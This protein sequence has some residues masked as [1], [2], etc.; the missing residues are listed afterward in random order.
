MIGDRNKIFFNIVHYILS[1]Q[2]NVDWILKSSFINFTGLSTE[3][4]SSKFQKP[5]LINEILEYLTEI[6]PYH[7]KFDQF[8][9][10][11]TSKKDTAN[12]QGDR[13]TTSTG[14]ILIIPNLVEFFNL[15]YSIRFD[16]VTLNPDEEKY[17]SIKSSDEMYD[18]Y[19]T[20]SANRLYAL[21]TKDRDLIKELLKGGFKGLTVDGGNFLMDRVGYDSVPYDSNLYD[22]P[23]ITNM[24]FI[25]DYN[26]PNLSNY[27]KE[28]ISIG[29]NL[30]KTNH[31][32]PLNRNNLKIISEY[33]DKTYEITDYNI[34][35]DTI[36]IFD[37]IRQYE[38]ITITVTDEN[39][40][41]TYY[42]FTGVDFFEDNSDTGVK[43]FI[44]YGTISFPIPVNTYNMKAMEVY[45]ENKN[46]SRTLLTNYSMDGNNIIL[47]YILD[48]FNK[49]IISIIDYE[50][51]YDKIYTYED[52]YA[53]ANNL[54]YLD[55]AGFLRPHW[56]DNHPSE[57]N[58]SRILNNMFIKTLNDDNTFNKVSFYNYLNKNISVD[59]EYAER[60]ELARELKIGDK[61][62]YVNNAKILQQPSKTDNDVII[63][64]VIL[65]DNELIEFHYMNNNILSGIKRACYGSSFKLSYPANT[66]VYDVNGNNSYNVSELPYDYIAYNNIDTLSYK[67]KGEINDYSVINVFKTYRINMLNNLSPTSTYI[68]FDAP[69]QEN[70]NPISI[71]Y[72]I[73]DFFKIAKTDILGIKIG[74][75]VIQIEF[76]KDIK[77]I[78]SLITYLNNN[79]PAIYNL[80]I[81][82]NDDIISFTSKNGENIT[83]YN[84]SGYPIQALFNG[85]LIGT[86]ERPEIIMDGKSGLA[87][88]NRKIIWGTHKYKIDDLIKNPIQGDVND[89]IQS[90]NKNQI[91]SQSILARNNS[92]KL[93]IISLIGENITLSNIGEQNSLEICG[94][95]E[96]L[97]LDD[98][99][100]YN[101]SL[102]SIII[103]KEK[104]DI[105]SSIDINGYKIY[106]QTY[107]EY[108][109]NG[110]RM[111]SIQNITTDKTINKDDAI[112]LSS[113]PKEL[114]ENVDYTIDGQYI[115]LKEPLKEYEVIYITNNK[116]A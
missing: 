7:T 2:F 88:N 81:T 22:A 107:N 46:G 64:G 10:K 93:E 87:I 100:S 25:V 99:I 59:L 45:I 24:Y 11:Y 4:S 58:I 75:N 31:P 104:I 71:S 105:P 20:T 29:V 30:L 3:I 57:L 72:K 39:Y 47:P 78:K 43:E 68:N 82:Y 5:S 103:S 23:T 14:E 37:G 19:N 40:N 115:T 116:G 86:I 110:K 96:S 49:I 94:L 33:K 61:E 27:T 13:V 36:N 54:M 95:N 38:K 12:I 108:I 9:E 51:I 114:I 79:I 52:I 17:N 18:F 44:Q 74:N 26:E 111:S 1:E 16:N 112:I 70:P 55:G 101:K 106:F 34:I 8:I 21:H 63:P 84:I 92:D 60:T 109:E 53:S 6:K 42:I 28:F 113:T 73:K 67:I 80:S 85:A 48:E 66:L 50:Y 35:H 90:I 89:M 69:L 83:L 77:T 62:I 15:E 98:I 41:P 32:F 76:T 56:Q 97:E 91:L 102:N 65:I